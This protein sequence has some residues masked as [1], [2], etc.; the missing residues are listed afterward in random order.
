MKL[1][2]LFEPT[3][4]GQM[5]LKNRIAMAP[6]GTN[7]PG[8]E[9]AVTQRA[10]RFYRERAKGGIGLIIVE[11]T[12][13]DPH[14]MMLPTEFNIWIDKALPSFRQLSAT[15]KEYDVKTSIQIFHIGAAASSK[16][17]G[18]Q[19]LSPSGIRVP[20]IWEIP[21]VMTEKEIDTAIETYADGAKRAMETG[22]D[23]VQ[24]HAAEG[25]PQQFLSPYYNKRTDEYGGDFD[26]RMKFLIDIMERVKETVG[27]DFPVICRINGEDRPCQITVED[28]QAVAIRLEK[29]GVDAIELI[30]GSMLESFGVPTYSLE[31]H[32][33][34]FSYLAEGVKRLV[35]IPVISN[36][37]INDPFAAEKILQEGIADLVSISRALIADPDFP[38]KAAS[39]R[40]DEINRCI[41]CMTCLSEA[42]KSNH[43]KCAVNAQAGFEGE[44]QIN[45]V[46]KV[47]KILV[48][49]GGPAGL[50]AARVA[51]LRGHKVTLYEKDSLLGGQVLVG[52]KAPHKK[53]ILNL[54]EYLTTQIKKI[55]VDIILGCEANVDLVRNEKPDAVIVAT[56]ALPISPQIVAE[57]GNFFFASDILNETVEAGQSVLVVGGGSVGAETAEFLACKNKQVTIVEILDNVCRDLPIYA[58]DDLLQ[59]LQKLRINILTGTN[60][61]KIKGQ[62]VILEKN[63]QKQTVQTD[64][65]II[66][67]GY[68]PN[69]ELA[70]ELESIVPEL[71]II[72]DCQEPRKIFE[73]IHEGFLIGNKI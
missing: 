5:A 35:K 58:R 31:V 69:R 56:G 25:L 1:T 17:T 8:G 44:R 45:T 72:G 36:I 12:V 37:R 51:A 73:A 34:H 62:N 53:E 19:P 4:I 41:A 16:L 64:T 65:I 63:G 43:V 42:W 20:G 68:K 14:G 10:I 13:N 24:I 38:N 61:E 33:G 32:P 26:G 3:R 30:N 49:G 7:F 18:K 70:K 55:G 27:K 47:K 40:L 6:T 67:A 9:G 66:A 2:K 54:V 52:S 15:I 50:E 29:V 48:V 21:K 39:G 23:S 60:V 28:S 46:D 59:R 11:G 57:E 22:F 71:H